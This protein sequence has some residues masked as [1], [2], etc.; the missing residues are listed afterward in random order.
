[1]STHKNKMVKNKRLISIITVVIVTVTLLW[2]SD[3]LPKKVAEVVA[4]NYVSKQE[5]GN[6]Y[7]V[8][9]VDY[10]PAHNCYFVYFVNNDYEQ[11]NIGIYYRYFPFDAYYDSKYPG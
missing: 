7:K 10:S 2:F 4:I 9:G 1:M 6:N 8:T 11:R 5:D 3:I